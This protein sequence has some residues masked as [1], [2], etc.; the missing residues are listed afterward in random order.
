M[1][2]RCHTRPIGSVDWNSRAYRQA[3]LEGCGLSFA[4]RGRGSKASSEGRRS[5]ETSTA[6]EALGK[7]ES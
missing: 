2:L 3:V 1:C 7:V 6:L 4:D 5:N